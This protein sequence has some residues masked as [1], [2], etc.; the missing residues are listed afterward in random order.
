MTSI[1]YLVSCISQLE[2]D[3]IS[4]QINSEEY[5]KQYRIDINKA[6]KMHKQ[7]IENAYYEI[8][9]SHPDNVFCIT[10]NAEEYYQE[11]FNK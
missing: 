4:N 6:K 11:T 8:G 9:R 3:L 10:K 2:W 7:E 1:E 5:G